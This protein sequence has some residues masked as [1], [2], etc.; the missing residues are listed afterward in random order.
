MSTA[1]QLP[2]DWRVPVP[3]VSYR[4]VRGARAC[5]AQR[6][7]GV[8]PGTTVKQFWLRLHDSEVGSGSSSKSSIQIR[9]IQILMILNLIR[10][11][12]TGIRKF[13]ALS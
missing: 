7:Y 11:K 8:G 1:S 12:V 4:T 5:P 13:R 6:V 9:I 3:I 2:A 10:A